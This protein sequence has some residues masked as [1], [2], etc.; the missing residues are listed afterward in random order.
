MYSSTLMKFQ[1]IQ[2]LKVKIADSKYQ[3]NVITLEEARRERLR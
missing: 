3:G 1:S 2:K